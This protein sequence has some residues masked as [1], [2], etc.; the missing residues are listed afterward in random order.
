MKAF[1]GLAQGVQNGATE[2]FGYAN[3]T[4]GQFIINMPAMV[5][6]INKTSHLAVTCFE[7]LHSDEAYVKSLISNQ[8]NVTTSS[9]LSASSLSSSNSS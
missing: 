5:N 6:A 9:L 1:N 8:S 3:A 7:A 4:M 2:F